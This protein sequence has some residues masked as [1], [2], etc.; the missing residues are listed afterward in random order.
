MAEKEF[1][2]INIVENWQLDRSM[3][4]LY[5]EARPERQIAQVIDLNKCL[6]CHGCSLACKNCW[7]FSRGQEHMWWSNVETKPFGGY[8]LNWDIKIL[9]MLDRAETTKVF[10]HELGEY[11]RTLDPKTKEVGR[12]VF[13][14]AQ[15][16]V[17]RE[18]RVLGYLPS[19]EEWRYPNINEDVAREEDGNIWSFYLPRTC[20]QC[21]FPA[22]L[23]ACPRNA[24]YKRLADKEGNPLDGIVLIDQKRCRGYRKCMEACPY[25]KVMYRA[26]TRKTESCIGCYPKVETGEVS[27]CVASCAGKARL[28]GWVSDEKSPVYHLV[29]EEGVALPLYPQFGTE[30]NVYYIP[31]RLVPLKFIAQMFGNYDV[32]VV[33]EALDRYTDPN[34]KTMGALKLFGVSNKIIESYKVGKEAVEAYDKDGKLIIALPI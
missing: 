28:Q 29:R 9:E 24:I 32:D 26:N 14:A 23:A 12:T 21:T 33:R 27:L 1:E 11:R 6:G 25:K 13:E 2:Q 20:N 22:C 3:K 34:S 7:T 17:R 31:P 16:A 5:E 30:P 15:Y 10:D 8:P 19:D 4:Y 18:E